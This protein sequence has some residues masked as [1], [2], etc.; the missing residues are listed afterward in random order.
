MAPDKPFQKQGT[1]KENGLIRV[2]PKSG[3]IELRR[4]NQPQGIEHSQIP[5]P[6]DWTN[7]SRECNKVGE[8]INRLGKRLRLIG[9]QIIPRIMTGIS[10]IVGGPIA[11]GNGALC[12]RQR[13]N[14]TL[15]LVPREERKVKSWVGMETTHLGHIFVSPVG[16]RGVYKQ[17][18]VVCAL[19]VGYRILDLLSERDMY[20]VLSDVSM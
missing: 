4:F 18:A 5:R 8:G 6:I 20:S 10:S 11:G 9:V 13:S 2:I 15:L 3:Q 7:Q 19:Y 14:S 17:R 12:D 1:R 16:E